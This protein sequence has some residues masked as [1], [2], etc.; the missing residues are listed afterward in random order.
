MAGIDSLKLAAPFFKKRDPIA[1]II[2]ESN[3]KII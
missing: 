3:I 2:V 1:P